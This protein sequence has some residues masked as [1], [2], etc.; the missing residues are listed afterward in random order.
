VACVAS[1]GW[2]G[3][4]GGCATG[5]VCEMATDISESSGADCKG[6]TRD[7]TKLDSDYP[8]RVLY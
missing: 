4:G 5:W 7:S 2:S 6:D 3:G 1:A 8:L